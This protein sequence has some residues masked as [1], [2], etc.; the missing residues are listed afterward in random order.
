MVKCCACQADIDEEKGDWG[1]SATKEEYICESCRDIDESSLSTIMLVSP[2]QKTIKYYVGEHTRMSEDGDDMTLSFLDV[3]R[4]WVSSD[5]HRGH[6][7]TTIAGWEEVLVGWTT[8]AWGDGTSNRKQSFNDWANDVCT[9]EIQSLVPLAIVADPTS[10]LFS[11]GIS[12]LTPEP[13][14][15]KE[16][17]ESDFDDLSDS[18][19]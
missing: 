8:G 11:M 16:W 13:E 10:N 3:D 9:G 5:A 12:V 2:G 4:V 17:F 18:L 6:Y 19:A 15:F 7:N 1:W 14:K